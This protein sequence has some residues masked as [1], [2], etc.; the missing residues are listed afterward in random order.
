MIGIKSTAK[1]A[2]PTMDIPK[3]IK[4][5]PHIF[6]SKNHSFTRPHSG[7]AI[8]SSTHNSAIAVMRGPVIAHRWFRWPHQPQTVRHRWFLPVFG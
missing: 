5:R 3:A 8:M 1:T 7:G 6:L 2:A 4:T